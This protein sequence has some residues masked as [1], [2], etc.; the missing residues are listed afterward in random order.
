MEI[1][2][3]TVRPAWLGLVGLL[4][5]AGC[6]GG[7]SEPA[8]PAIKFADVARS[9]VTEPVALDE[10]AFVDADGK[11]VVIGELRRGRP[12]VLVFTRGF[13][14]SICLY[15][16]AQTSRWGQ[17]Y[18]ELG[19]HEAELVLVFPVK[20]TD[21]AVQAAELQRRALQEIG[22]NQDELPFPILIDV[23][24]A[25]VEK[26]GITEQLSKPATYVMDSDGQVR[27]AYVGQSMADRPTIDSVIDQL[28]KL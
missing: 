2:V 17:R 10:L 6:Q 7:T 15:C 28:K 1:H 24:L 13:A 21:D 8:N 25:M 23:G 16:T 20:T 18:S 27:F 4:L 19:E 9:N 14:N 12:L 3:R 11:P 5:V 26:L 22:S